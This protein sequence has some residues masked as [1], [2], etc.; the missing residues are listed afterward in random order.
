M[1]GPGSFAE[2]LSIHVEGQALDRLICYAELVE[3]WSARHNLVRYSTRQELVERHIADALAAA[4]RL[5]AEGRLL[6]VGSGAGLP[7]VPLLA[8]RPRWRGVLLE[9]RQKRWAFLRTVI[10]ELFGVDVANLTPVQALVRLNEWQ[11]R[12]RGE[13]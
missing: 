5:G 12:L 1:S 6:D 9:P 4:P 8:A 7:G 11:R 10:R 3:R 13:A 2:L